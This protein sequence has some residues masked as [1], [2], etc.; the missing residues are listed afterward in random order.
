MH[1]ELFPFTPFAERIWALR[2]NLTCCD[3][4]YVALG[5][6]LITLDRKLGRATGAQPT[7]F[8][9]RPARRQERNSEPV[10]EARTRSGKRPSSSWLSTGLPE[11]P[12]F[13]VRRFGTHASGPVRPAI[14]G[15]PPRGFFRHHPVCAATQ[16]AGKMPFGTLDSP[17][18]RRSAHR[19]YA[20]GPGGLRSGAG[21]NTRVSPVARSTLERM[22]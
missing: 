10:D 12:G 19:A 4:W 6:P 2:S 16:L 18:F 1:L 7:T 11:P 3:A 5:C 22:T 21:R 8:S 9:P 17:L 15:S 20:C 13:V 14:A